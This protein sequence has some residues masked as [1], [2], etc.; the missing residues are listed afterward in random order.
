MAKRD[1]YEVLGVSRDASDD[2]IKHAYRELSKKW[3]PDVNKAP[4]AEQKFKEINEAY[5]VLSDPQKRAQYDQYGQAGMNG[6]GAGAGGFGNAGGFGG[7][8][9]AGGAGGFGGFDDIFSQ[10]FG[11]GATTQNAMA[12][13]QGQDLQYRMDL[14]FK[15]AIFGTDT[16]IQYDRTATCQTCH[17]SGAAP[18]TSPVTCHK[19]HG[20]GYIEIQ[21]QTPIGIMRTRE[22]CDVCHGTGKEIKDK[23][24]T[25]H[26]SG[27]VQEKHTLKVKVPAGVDDGQ[28][29]RLDGQGDAGE[30][31]GPYG[32]LYVVFRVQPSKE[33]ERDGF[34]I[35]VT[36]PITFAQ[37]AL[38]DEI[39]VDTVHGPVTLKVPAGTQ[40]GTNFRL[41][42]KGV[43]KLQGSGNGDEHVR[44]QV[45]TPKNMNPKQREALEAFSAAGGDKIKPQ[46][47]NLFEKMRDKLRGEE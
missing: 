7:F 8:G 29:M 23:C 45:I 40:S 5:E 27:H 21:R 17:G 46:E 28:Q 12:P 26:G 14:S 35:Y 32:D 36:V 3:H 38:G 2:D 47:K 31:G 39:N 4:D 30:N 18:G 11:G 10:F 44:V 19:C 16:E 34:E 13:R 25:C 42:G 37:A 1:Y 20:S 41:R 22:V 33:F 43:P 24:P 15:D 9:N 6:A